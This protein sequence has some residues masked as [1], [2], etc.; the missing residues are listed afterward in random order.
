[1]STEREMTR[2]VRSWLEQGVTRLP[3]RVLDL[4]LDQ[5]PATP[6]RRPFWRAWRFQQMTSPVRYAVATA[7][8]LAV[9]LVGYQFLPS[10]TGTGGEQ[11]AAPSAAPASQASTAAPT[12]SAIFGAPVLPNTDSLEAGRYRPYPDLNLTV[13]APAGWAT[14]C[15]SP[16]WIIWKGGSAEGFA[17]SALLFF[18]DFTEVTVYADG[19]KWRSGATS[20]PDGA[21]A[22][23]QAFA[24]REGSE[25]TSVTVAGLSAFHVQ[26]VVPGDLK[27]ER[28]SDGDATFVDCDS[29]EYRHWLTSGE[30]YAQ[31]I[32]QIEDLYLVDVDDRTLAFSLSHFPRT[33][34]ADF[35]A[36]ET[37][38]ASVQID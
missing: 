28:Q 36:L 29:G 8:V 34:A 3:D 23:A 26:L 10:N 1:M 16:A 30:R 21:E 2:V 9:A 22:V 11:S 18:E 6:Q 19:C 32:E 13:Q 17:Q 12:A 25:A 24:D 5:V 20:Q 14:C 7:A 31:D 27:T 15:E 38:L 4:V 35:R 33:D 37:M